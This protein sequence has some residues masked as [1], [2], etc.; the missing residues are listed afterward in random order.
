MMK[1][2]STRVGFG[3][4]LVILGERNSQIV[5]LDA[6]TSCSTKTQVFAKRFPQRF[7][8]VG[9]AEQNLIGIAA[10][11]SLAGKIAFAGSYSVFVSGKAWDQIRNTVCYCNLNVN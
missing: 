10:G 8:N 11:L 2:C 1:M 6:D 7:F 9:V 5:V 4:G 3:E